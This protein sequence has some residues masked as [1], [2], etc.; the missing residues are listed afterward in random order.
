MKNTILHSN[1]S[2]TKCLHKSKFEGKAKL[3]S[4]ILLAFLFGININLCY[5][6]ISRTK[7]I[8]NA[9]SYVNFSWTANSCNLWSGE[10]CGN[11][12]VY[13]ATPANST[14][15][16]WVKVG[17]NTSMPYA[18]GGYSSKEQHISA[19]SSC[20]SAGD[21]C[22]AG[23]V[24]GNCK[25]QGGAGA[26]L[27]C[28][29]GLDCSGL[30]TK[31]WEMPQ[32]HLG[33][34]ELPSYSTIIPISQMQ[35]GDI[36]NDV[37][38]HTMLF[39]SK[40]PDG[41][42]T[43]IETSGRDWKTTTRTVY[44]LTELSTYNSR[45]P[46]SDIVIGGCGG[47][48]TPTND[49]PCDAGVP[50]LP[51]GTSC[52]FTQGTNVG[53]TNSNVP[54]L[55]N[56]DGT[57]NGDVWFKFQVPS[58][59]SVII[60]TDAVN[61]TNEDMGMALYT[62][63]NCNSLSYYGCYPNGSSYSQYMPRA[64]L[65]G[66]SPNSTMW[67]RMW[68][69]N[70]NNFGTFKICVTDPSPSSTPPN[71]NPCD[72]GVP[73]LTVG[74]SCSFTQGTN[75]GATNSGVPNISCDGT[76]NGDVWFKFQVPSSGSVI[77]ETDAVNLTNE[78]M[79]MA[80]Y[81]GSNCNSLSYYNC[82]PNGSSYSQYMPRAEITGLTPNATMWIR[83]WEYNN[84]NF[85]TF[86]ICVTG[87]SST[88][89]PDLIVQNPQISPSTVVMGQQ[90]TA[91]C[92][93]KNQGTGNASSSYTA[94][95]FSA[96]LNF[97]GTP[98]DI[99]LN[100]DIY[101]PALNANETSSLLSK[102]FNI[103][104]GPYAGTWYIMFGADAIN[105]NPNESNENNNQIFIPIT[106][107]STLTVSPSSLSLGAA[108]GSNDQISVSSNVSWSA[109]DNASWLSVSPSNG[110]NNGTVTVTAASENTST[111]SRSATV[112]ISGNGIT[113]NVSVTQNGAAS[114]LT[115]SPSSLSLGAASGSNDQISVSSN[116]SWSASD[117][118]SWLSVSPSNG[119]N[120]GTVTVTAT[121][122]NTS[123]NSRSATVTISGNGITR[124]VSVTQNGAASTLTVSPSSLS[125]GAAS[126]SNDQ[127]SVSSNVSWSASD[128]ASWLSVSPSNGSNNGTVTVTATSENTSTN[129]RS[130][131]VTI[132]G[133][134]IT[135]NVSVTQNGAAASLTVSPS[136]LS[137]GAASGSNDQISVS[138]NV[139]WSASD[140]ASWLSVSP[141]NG[142]NN[143]TVTVT[144]TS[145][146]TSTNSRSATV[147]ISGNG[148]T[149][150]VSVTQNG[151][152][153]TLTVSPSSLSLGAASG[154]NDQI[155]VSSNVSWSASDNAS[156]LSV[157]PSNGSNNGTVTV[158]AT[159]ENTST[160]SRSATVTISGN[161][162]TR[163]VSVTQ[164]GAAASLTVSPS[165][166]S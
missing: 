120:N 75:V 143:G 18:W 59:G 19:M 44:N 42:I 146:N 62:G 114:T 134:G 148:I 164:N 1:A 30:I 125:L 64:E 98:T 149:R 40:N 87:S 43:V 113:R 156:W 90:V 39:K 83:M 106:F 88:T 154:S 53:A 100:A 78:D 157:S 123:T 107:Q 33:T 57:S 97:D 25:T 70:N 71:D 151:A 48:T 112:T 20:K 35:P 61:L 130:A 8:S 159:S 51:V 81:T 4:T 23:T 2:K 24:G 131:T 46:K 72:A 104:M 144:A 79:G 111:N 128:N 36:F 14:Q 136:S 142:S 165:S 55:T 63:S 109:S 121:S 150:N 153:S 31:A 162:I 21:I 41:S 16:G 110:S 99:N 127:I 101:V 68:E 65:T 158:T 29:S 138:S 155:S 135:R 86:S 122:E 22:S 27:S 118:A 166:L 89:K 38:V 105:T 58:S 102:Q 140:N 133:N 50:T 28:A 32:A 145:E 26:G 126:G 137:L 45:C 82:Y 67:I 117:N 160:N 115:V 49:N 15:R 91:T 73:T 92:Y 9:E 116:V 93:I 139:S 108:S 80:L 5:S 95:W 152:A 163:N 96:D 129:S 10:Y 13:A 69:Y 94:L 124:N 66:L 76:S 17:T 56:C 85:G 37:G 147:T 7:I 6:Q 52:S 54:I 161:G 74:T 141:S 132:S 103:P 60:E 34:G 11:R 84:N 77:I 47:V 119:S 12:Y 3:F